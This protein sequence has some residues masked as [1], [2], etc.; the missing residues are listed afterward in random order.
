MSLRIPLPKVCTFC[1]FLHTSCLSLLKW[2]PL[3]RWSSQWVLTFRWQKNSHSGFVPTL[4]NGASR[5]TSDRKPKTNDH[6]LPSPILFF[7]S[8][9]WIKL[10]PKTIGNRKEIVREVAR[11][12]KP[13]LRKSTDRKA[14]VS[15][16][17]E[18]LPDVCFAI[19]RFSQVRFI[20]CY[21]Y[22]SPVGLGSRDWAPTQSL[23]PPPPPPQV[24]SCGRLRAR[25][26]LDVIF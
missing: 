26:I 12:N 1:F 13:Y 4:S 20:Y 23:T 2:S 16:L 14:Q 19:C 15:P 6:V 11:G 17:N 10:I 22:P 24:E 18:R 21:H 5:G 7:P 25:E 3:W 8:K 9:K